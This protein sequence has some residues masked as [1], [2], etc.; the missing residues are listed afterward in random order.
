M[1]DRTYRATVSRQ[2]VPDATREDAIDI[3]TEWARL[4]EFRVLG[5][6]DCWR[7]FDGWQVVL[8]VE[9]IRAEVTA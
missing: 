2:R 6:V 3:V 9:P 4:D 8:E 1:S 5:T 7:S